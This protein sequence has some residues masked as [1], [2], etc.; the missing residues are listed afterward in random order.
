M[1]S[2]ALRVTLRLLEPQD[3]DV[4][5]G[6]GE[7]PQ[8]CREADWSTTMASADR[9]RFQQSLIE[10]PPPELI[11]WGAVVESVLVGYV[12]LQGAE[13]GRR[14]LGFVIGERDR[15]GSGLGG[16]AAAAGLDHGFGR[17]GLRHVWA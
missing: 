13:P 8:F 3:A 12:D 14:E 15:W 1:D 9:R 11:R 7:D 10:A 5:A 17:L 2:G 4:I 16:L 6:W